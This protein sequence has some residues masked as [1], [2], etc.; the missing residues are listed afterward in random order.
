MITAFKSCEK[1][2]R[3][4]DMVEAVQHCTLCPRLCNRT[5]V[6]SA[7]NGNL[8]SRVL[9]VAEAPGRLGA[10]RTGIPLHGDQTGNNF[11]KLL[12]NVGWNRE[13]L[14]ITNAILCNPRE[15][16][17]NNGTPSF[18]EISNCVYYLA[19][20]IE[21]VNPDVVVSLG[22]TAPPGV[23]D[24]VIPRP[25]PSRSRWRRQALG[26]SN[27]GSPV[28]PRP[29]GTRTPQ[30]PQADGRFF[31]SGKGGESGHRPDQEEAK[32]YR[33]PEHA[34]GHGFAASTPRMHDRAEA[35]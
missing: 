30:L 11:E 34:A 18:D 16:N 24:C 6:L 15:E 31:A 12:G 26:E 22:A 23:G 29:T 19:M 10:D 4:A 33:D 7:K 1:Q 5:K 17:G 25:E 27:I 28:S 9:F 32:E 3:F 35:R 20:T 2:S 13:D 8:D 14:F 21:L